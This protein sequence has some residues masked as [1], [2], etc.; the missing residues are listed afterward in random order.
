MDKSQVPVLSLLVAL[1]VLLVYHGN[2]MV[3]PEEPALLFLVCSVIFGV[4]LFDY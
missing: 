3:P 2:T 1:V 4:S